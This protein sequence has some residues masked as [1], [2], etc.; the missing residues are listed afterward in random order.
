MNSVRIVADS[1]C[2]LPANLVELYQITIV[3]VFVRFG[4]EMISSDELTNEE[5]W[6]RATTGKD[7]PGT[8]SPAFRLPFHRVFQGLWS[9]RGT[10]WSA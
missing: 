2:D 1:G 4:R 7:L 5:F 9:R 10:M 3:P 8:S 6:R